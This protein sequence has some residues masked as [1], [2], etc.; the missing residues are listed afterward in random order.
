MSKLNTLS[1]VLVLFCSSCF[2]TNKNIK[3]NQIS[4]IEII[5]KQGTYKMSFS[6]IGEV[7]CPCQLTI[8]SNGQKTHKIFNLENKI[9]MRHTSDWYGETL[10]FE[11]SPIACAGNNS[12]MKL[13]LYD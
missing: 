4:D 1:I 11:L 12:Y 7:K 8:L 3:L 2:G 9:N 5:P 6:L 13:V 10:S